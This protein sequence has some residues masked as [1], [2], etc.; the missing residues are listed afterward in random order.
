M[1]RR[2]FL[3]LSALSP[4]MAKD[5]ISKGS[6]IYLTSSDMNTVFSLKNRLKSLKRFVGYANFN[7]ISYD[8]ALYYARNYSAIGKFTKDEQ[9]LIEKLFFSDP[10]E[11]NFYG[12]K[13]THSLTNKISKKDIIKIPHTGHF[14]YKG[15]PQNDYK[16][17]LKDVGPTLKLTSGIRNVIK[18]LDLYLNKLKK[19]DGDLVK[20]SKIIAPPAFSY[21]TIHD[22][23]I[24]RKDWGAKNFT[25]AFATTKEFKKIRKLKY[26][27][28]R[29]TT[30][31]K[32]G[33][34]Y[35]PWHIKVI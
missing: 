7:I 35:E 14:L 22:F 13:T 30:N 19:Y 16:R 31:N 26:V 3:I 29:Y 12:K 34:R 24:G 11:F 4:V 33:V 25:A 23:D 17:L 8:Q 27:D 18:Q 6:D 1:D 10:K 21:H 20:A 9:Y 2:T 5:F 15:K 32:D 28:I